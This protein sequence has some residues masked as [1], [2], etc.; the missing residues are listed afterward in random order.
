MY[1]EEVPPELWRHI[2]AFLPVRALW[3][4]RSVNRTFLDIAREK[5]YD[6]VDFTAYKTAKP[7]LELLKDSK[8]VHSIRVQPWMVVPKELKSPAWRSIYT[9]LSGC[10]RLE[11]FDDT[12]EAHIARRVQKQTRRVTDIVK[13]LPELHKYHIDWDEGPY[14]LEFFSA[15]LEIVPKIGGRLQTLN[16]KVPLYFMPYLPTLAGDLPALEHLTLTI[17]TGTF[18]A[19]YISQQMEGLIIFVNNNVLRNL[20]TLSLYTT[21]TSTFLD[22][23][24]FFKNLG[25]GRRLTSFTLCIPFDGGHLADPLQLRRFLLNHNSTLQSI[26]LGTTRAA[27]HQQPSP[28]SAKYWIRETL[29]HY[30]R[31]PSLTRLSLGLRPLRSDLAPLER[32]LFTMRPQLHVL[33]LS[34][35]P[36]EYNE[37]QRVVNTLDCPPLLRML[38]LRLRWLSPEIVDL[39]ASGLPDLTALELTFT[40]IVHQEATDSTSILSASSTGLSRESELT[41]FCQVMNGKVYPDWRLTR[42]AIP[43]SPYGQMKWLNPLEPIFVEC[44]PGLTSFAELVPP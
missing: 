37:L 15:I 18:T 24:P 36:L 5:R 12:P 10:H 6:D 35:R 40:E 28:R 14:H 21:P 19:A 8:L 42:L 2:A 27:A 30:P 25:H 9:R 20:R 26:D 41:L 7:L 17:H 38:S 1:S 33:K 32:C 31:P 23:G 4:V 3:K 34:E 16:L 44:I 29:K 39:L 22:L 11:N 13:G 43:E